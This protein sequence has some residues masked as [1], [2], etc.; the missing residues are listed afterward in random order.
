M[1]KGI[2]LK[3]RGM[4]LVLVT[5][6]MLALIG[7][8]ALSIDVNHAMLNKTRLQNSVDAAAL[9]AAIVLDNGGSEAQATAA[10]K[11]T[12]TNVANA[13]G[14]TEMDFTSAQVVVQFSNDPA[15]FPF[16]GFDPDE[17]SYARVAVSNFALS[18]FFAHVFSVDKNLA[19]TAVAGPSPSNTLVTNVVPIAVCEG[20]DVGT[21]GYDQGSIYALKI[22]DQNQSQMGPG[23]YQLLD[24]GSG[25]STVR[26]ALA[27]GY[28]GAID[29][30]KPVTT[31]PG[32]TIGPVGQ[33]LNTRFDDYSGGGVSSTDYPPDVYVKEPVKSAKLDNDG[34]VDYS[35]T[36]GAGG[37]PWGY[38]DYL[39][40]LPDC[41][42]DSACRINSGGQENRR[43]LVIPVVDC[44]GASGGTSNF[45]V[46]ALACFF[47][48]QQAPTNNSGK[49]A[50]FGEFIEDCTVSGGV[51]GQNSSNDGPYRIVLYRDP[52][53][54][55][56]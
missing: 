50:V 6:A 12:L 42:G 38:A 5:A 44:T 45:N 52:H 28:K 51:P 35:D 29:I 8:A 41:T 17:D 37:Q 18:N 9:A 56:S 43:I 24:F 26:E 13:T 7:V 32:N 1:T 36:S 40:A 48:L 54:E 10:A 20:E 14:N 11:T 25:A 23:N 27:G 33:G 2:Q 55:E 15:T 34:N 4:T 47:M 3:Q 31:K 21:N 46:T 53:G 16:S 19:S 49:E 30:S 22:A 39:A